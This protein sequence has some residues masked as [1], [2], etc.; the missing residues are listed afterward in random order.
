MVKMGNTKENGGN[1]NNEGKI[2]QKTIRYHAC[3]T[4]SNHSS[5]V[6]FGRN[7]NNV[8]NGRK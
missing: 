7:N 1:R 4:S 6:D 3:S 2:K 5:T 8:Y